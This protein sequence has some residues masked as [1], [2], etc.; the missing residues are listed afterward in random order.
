MELKG[1]IRIIDAYILHLIIL[2]IIF[3]FLHYQIDYLFATKEFKQTNFCWRWWRYTFRKIRN[4]SANLILI[5]YAKGGVRRDALY[6]STYMLHFMSFCFLAL[7]STSV[8][9]LNASRVI[10]C[11]FFPFEQAIDGKRFFRDTNVHDDYTLHLHYM[12][13]FIENAFFYQGHWHA[14]KRMF[15]PLHLLRIAFEN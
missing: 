2:L 12:Q 8:F 9:R 13:W 1:L 5:R 6:A 4:V 15:N 11:F 7:Y 3:Y 14:D 10:K